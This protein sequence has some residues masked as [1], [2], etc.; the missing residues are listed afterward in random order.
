MS[1]VPDAYQRLRCEL[2]TEVERL[3]TMLMAFGRKRKYDG[4]RRAFGN[5]LG[6][7]GLR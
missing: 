1:N 6:A 3:N 4:W 2:D 7:K 5:K